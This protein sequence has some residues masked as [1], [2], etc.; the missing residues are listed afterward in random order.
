MPYPE[1]IPT[2]AVAAVVRIIR[3]GT[4]RAESAL[5]VESLYDLVGALLAI[6]F[7]DSQPTFGASPDGSLDEL[8]SLLASVEEDGLPTEGTFGADEKAIDPATILL[9]IQLVSKLIEMWKKRK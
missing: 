5:F 3:E 6:I 9:I 2:V 7:G 1:G 4:I 8:A